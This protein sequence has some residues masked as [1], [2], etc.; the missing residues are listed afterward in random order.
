ML[1]ADVSRNQPC[2][3]AELDGLGP[4]FGPQFVEHSA[5][6]SL[7]RVLADKQPLGYFSVAEPGSNQA[8]N[9][10]FA[11]CDTQFRH[12]LFVEFEAAAI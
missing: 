11:R 4:P 9:F 12:P 5:R 8:K 10:Q 2:V 1:L 3:F 7:Y 6:V